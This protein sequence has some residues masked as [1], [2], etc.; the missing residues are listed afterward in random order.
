MFRSLFSKTKIHITNI[1]QF[2]ALGSI[3]ASALLAFN[4][5]F[6]ANFNEICDETN[7]CTT[8]YKC[9]SE[10]P[11]A[12]TAKVCLL[13]T[14]CTSDSDCN[15]GYFCDG[16]VAADSTNN[17]TAEYGMCSK[18]A[19]APYVA[20]SA[21]TPCRAGFVC[22]YYAS[23]GKNVCVPNAIS[24]VLCN[25]IVYFTD[26]LVLTF[27]LFST[28]ML[29]IAFFLGKISWGMIMTI[30]IGSALVIG[31]E[32]TIKEIAKV[33]SE[34]FCGIRANVTSN[35]FCSNP[36]YESNTSSSSGLV[37]TTTAVLNVD[38][39]PVTP[40]CLTPFSCTRIICKS[41]SV[42]TT[43]TNGVTTNSCLIDPS[44]SVKKWVK[45]PYNI[46]SET[47]KYIGSYSCSGTV[48]TT[49]V[50]KLDFL[51]MDSNPTV[52]LNSKYFSCKITCPDSANNSNF[53]TNYVSYRV[54]DGLNS[55]TYSL[56]N[57][58]SDF[59]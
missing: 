10:F 30:I 35:S 45:N 8:G 42:T 51:K 2:I 22:E 40:D 34:G 9:V 48:D 11:G 41:V 26:K 50:C 23:S 15:S 25:V 36:I 7:T 44:Y 29:G 54:T 31:S 28:S 3:F 49:D 53:G 1:V 21:D 12:S 19:V 55:S 33:S 20:C 58:C 52:P 43:T 47:A 16:Y 5:S 57:S 6:A 32:E 18:Q 14:V 13:S 27:M 39:D 59:K 56:R 37:D 38:S 17:K 46:Q 24:K 4:T